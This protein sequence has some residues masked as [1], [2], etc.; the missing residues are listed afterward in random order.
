[1][2]FAGTGID[3]NEP[4]AG[5]LKYLHNM[6]FTDIELNRKALS[7]SGGKIQQSIEYIVSGEVPEHGADD[8]PLVNLAPLP[9]DTRAALK[10][11]RSMGFKNDVANL[12]LLREFNNN[13]EQVIIHLVEA[14]NGP[15]KPG[16]GAD[17]LPNSSSAKT[18]PGKKGKKSAVKLSPSP[19]TATKTLADVFGA[20]PVWSPGLSTSPG[21]PSLS[22]SPNRIQQRTENN[23]YGYL[24]PTLESSPPKSF[25]S[26]R[27]Q[28]FDKSFGTSPTSNVTFGF[29]DTFASSSPPS[30]KIENRIEIKSLP[31]N[32]IRPRA[33]QNNI[34]PSFASVEEL[35][36]A[37]L[38]PT[39]LTSLMPTSSYSSL[40]EQLRSSYTTES[41][42]STSSAVDELVS[43][44]F[45]TSEST[46]QP[47][48]V[49]PIVPVP[50][51]GGHGGR[52]AD[53]L[54][55]I[56]AIMEPRPETPP[57]KS[58]PVNVVSVETESIDASDYDPF[59][60]ENAVDPFK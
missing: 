18:V 21:K 54:N 22:T 37:Q 45:N 20:A 25:S 42:Y 34:N 23:G 50:V 30:N 55:K 56:T 28:T 57:V 48:N 24:I 38:L 19:N 27:S 35:Q 52:S 46:S 49:R 2:D 16:S 10:E 13:V 31:T 12:E 8:E 17:F 59:S 11:L 44:D 32:S 51:A 7:K 47:T 1:M 60:D 9:A 15:V 53:F 43:V 41:K 5:Q 4:F 33:S 29:E 40:S 14:E 3:P 26:T 36:R 6:G 58:V 39:D